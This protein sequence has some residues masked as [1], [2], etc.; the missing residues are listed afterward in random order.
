MIRKIIAPAKA[1]ANDA[2]SFSRSAYTESACNTRPSTS[3][4]TFAKRSDQGVEKRVDTLYR[5]TI[6]IYPTA[7]ASRME[8]F[9]ISLRELMS[10]KKSC[11]LTAGY[12]LQEA[13][14]VP[15]SE[16]HHPRVLHAALRM[17]VLTVS[18]FEG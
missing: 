16:S 4:R 13:H 15:S 5:G 3:L 8:Q 2:S 6:S 7:P 12:A 10:C 9:C 18:L 14:S 1:R 17:S 11:Q